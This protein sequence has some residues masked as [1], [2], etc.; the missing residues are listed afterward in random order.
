ASTE[1]TATPVAMPNAVAAAYT[2]QDGYTDTA[3]NDFGDLTRASSAPITTTRGANT[4]V[5][6]GYAYDG[7]GDPITTTT[8][9]GA[10]VVT[11]YDHLGRP[12][13]TTRP[14][15]ALSLLGPTVA[16]NTS[17]GYDGDGNVITATDGA[18]DVTQAVYDASGRT[19]R[20]INP[21]G[22]STIY[23]Y[24]GPV[25]TDVQDTMGHTTHYD[26]DGA[27]RLIG[28]T[29]PTG[30]HTQYSPDAVGNATTITTPLDYNNIQANT[31]EQRGY[32]ALNRVISDTVGGIGATSPSASQTTT[33]SYDADGNVAQVQAT[34]T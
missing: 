2:Q 31:V 10:L 12:V 1:D 5:T 4:P 32:D 11:A 3:G 18:G 14:G 8:P 6:T 15:V 7:D 28:T 29:D 33:T 26:Y 20:T 21:V 19:I 22:A 13:R 16:I 9:N 27:D 30:V 34:A 25:L 23:A 24:S 17:L